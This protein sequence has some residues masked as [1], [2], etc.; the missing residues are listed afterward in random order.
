MCLC[1]ERFPFLKR[2]VQDSRLYT[3][4]SVVKILINFLLGDFPTLYLYEHKS[5]VWNIIGSVRTW[6]IF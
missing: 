1:L 6:F 5:S 4:K 2:K 3:V